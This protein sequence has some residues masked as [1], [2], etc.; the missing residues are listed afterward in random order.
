MRA[1]LF[2]P[3]WRGGSCSDPNQPV[4]SRLRQNFHR[5]VPVPLRT[6]GAAFLSVL[7]GHRTSPNQP[8]FN[9]PACHADP[10][11]TTTPSSSARAPPPRS[12][13]PVRPNA[14]LPLNTPPPPL[15]HVA[16]GEPVSL[17]QVDKLDLQYTYKEGA[18]YY[19]MDS[20]TY[21]EVSIDEKVVGDK[22]G[23]FLEG[24]ELSVSEIRQ[25][26]P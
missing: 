8:A 20:A 12:F 19:F 3:H 17:A 9:Q 1:F 13:P 18:M 5:N 24:M 21:E 26:W 23:F 2:I 11:L 15:P 10:D 25:A 14:F 16:Q 22:A 4:L 7:G 6:R